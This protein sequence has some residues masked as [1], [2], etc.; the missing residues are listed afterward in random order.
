MASK[1]KYYVVWE[2]KEKGIFDS[3]DK[4]KKSIESHQG[5]KYKAFLTLDKAKEAFNGNPSDFIGKDVHESL[6]TPEELKKIGKPILQSICVDAACS[7]VPGKMEYQGVFTFE[8]V[9]LFHQGPYED[10]TA[11]IGEFLAIVHALAW[12]KKRKIN[13]PIYSDSKT[14]MKWVKDKKSRTKL[15]QTKKN[16]VL[17]DLIERAEYWLRNNTWDNVL[18]KWETKAWG[19]I[20]ADFGRK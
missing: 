19:E 17:F 12:C 5:A 20:P 6:L 18:L 8:K 14:A 3:W 13:Y 11:N 2:G 9:L 15:I 16:A 4:C 7:G 10:G 1:K